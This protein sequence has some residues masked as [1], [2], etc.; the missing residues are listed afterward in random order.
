MET[1]KKIGPHGYEEGAAFD[2]DFKKSPKQLVDITIWSSDGPDGKINAISFKYRD[3]NND[4]VQIGPYG[5]I[6]GT[7]HTISITQGEYLTVI[8][9]YLNPSITALNFNT[10]ADA[11][12][13]QFGRCPNTGDT[14]FS[15]DVDH[16]SIVSLFGHCD[17]K[18]RSIGAYSGPRA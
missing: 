18:L 12:Y 14:H 13:G 6:E 9:G 10:S 1:I 16:D 2:I 5:S 3:E 11:K 15:I 4:L 17:D 7:K 8:S